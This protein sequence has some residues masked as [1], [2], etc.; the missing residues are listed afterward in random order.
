M[1]D[2]LFWGAVVLCVVAEGA[3]VRTSLRASGVHA[4]QFGAVP[5]V[6]RPEEIAWTVLPGL[7]LA[8]VLVLTWR[9]LHHRPVKEAPLQPAAHVHAS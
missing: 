4:E 1:A 6:R 8:V 9:T 3:L 2:V 7:V 5:R